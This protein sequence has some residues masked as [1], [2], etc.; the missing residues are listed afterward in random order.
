VFGNSAGS[1]ATFSVQIGKSVA[2]VVITA[3]GTGFT[4]GTN[5]PITFSSPTG[6]N[7]T[8]ATGTINV[9]GG[10]ITQFNF[11]T[12]GSGYLSTPTIT[13]PT[14]GSGATFT[15]TLST[16]GSIGAITINTGGTN[17]PSSTNLFGGC[18]FPLVSRTPSLEILNNNFGAF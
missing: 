17:Y 15:I 16:T 8:T 11:I 3:G 4:N 5:I 1:G 18:G 10:I 14:P 6:F 9:V 7:G 12:G 2:S 13:L